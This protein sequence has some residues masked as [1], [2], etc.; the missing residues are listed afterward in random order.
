MLESRPLS[1]DVKVLSGHTKTVSTIAWCPV[2]GDGEHEILATYVSDLQII[3]SE[4]HHPCHIG[5][6][7]MGRH[8]Y[9][10]Q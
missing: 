9:G 10:I 3:R 1:R 7:S 8:G 6:R 5:L 4:A 2:T